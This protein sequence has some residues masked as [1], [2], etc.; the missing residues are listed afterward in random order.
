MTI[1]PK[2]TQEQREC[3]TFP[4][5]SPTASPRQ[6]LIIEA[7]AGAGKTAVLAERVMWKLT[8]APQEHRV[9]PYE[10]FLAT[11]TR[12][13]D[14]ELRQRVRQLLVNSGDSQALQMSALINISTIDSL[15]M[16]LFE[17]HY[18]VFWE[19]AFLNPDSPANSP[20]MDTVPQPQ[21]VED[22][23]ACAE[24]EKGLVALLESSTPNPMDEALLLDFLLAGALKSLKA[25]GRR[26][27]RDEIL[28]F[29]NSEACLLAAEPTPE[30]LQDS[31]HPALRSIF[32]LLCEYG[33][34][35]HLK[36]LRSGQ[37]THTDRL[38][39]LHN[40]FCA[41]SGDMTAVRSPR[42]PSSLIEPQLPF[43]FRELIVD[44]YQDTNPAQHELLAR[45]AHLSQAR[46]IVVGDPKQSLYG[47]RR[48]KVSVFHDLKT[49]PNW[50]HVELLKNFRSAPE[51]LRELNT[52]S[53]EALSFRD[54]SIPEAFWASRHGQAALRNRVLGRDLLA[55]KQSESFATAP[56]TPR[57]QIY[58]QSLNKK[59]YPGEALD[60]G[61]ATSADLSLELLVQAVQNLLASGRS[62][63]ECVVLCETNKDCDLVRSA[64][65]RAGVP[66]VSSARA[67][68]QN[69]QLPFGQR[70]A[71]K[72]LLLVLCDSLEEF[73]RYSSL[74]AFEIFT[75]P[76]LD[77]SMPE[78]AM[79]VARVV[80]TQPL[81]TA[82]A[83][84]PDPEANWQQKLKEFAVSHKRSR[85]LAQSNLFAAWRLLARP[86]TDTPPPP[87]QVEDHG[88]AGQ[89][90][91]E[92]IF[93]SQMKIWGGRFSQAFENHIWREELQDLCKHTSN[94]TQVAI[95][96]LSLLPISLLEWQPQNDGFSALSAPE[97]LRVM[98][99]HGAKGLQWPV[100]FFMPK[101]SGGSDLSVFRSIDFSDRNVVQWL[102]K[103]DEH[104]EV[105]ERIQS[106][107]AVKPGLR[108]PHIDLSRAKKKTDQKTETS[109]QQAT[110][111]LKLQEKAEKL[112]E[113]SR[114]FYTA[115][116]RAEE[117]LV[118][119]AGRGRK[120]NTKSLR[121]H[122]SSLTL[123][124][125]PERRSKE[126]KG[127]IA[128]TLGS[129]VDN[130]FLLRSEIHAE[131]GRKRSKKTVEPWLNSE[132][133]Q[134]KPEHADRS[135]SYCDRSA[136]SFSDRLKAVEARLHD[137]SSSL[138]ETAWIEETAPHRDRALQP[139]SIKAP[140]WP[141][142]WEFHAAETQLTSGSG[143]AK[144]TLAA[145][146]GNSAHDDTPQKERRQ[147]G[148]I[149]LIQ[150]GL[151][152]HAERELEDP[153][154]VLPSPGANH[155]GA[156]SQLEQ[157]SVLLLREFE[158]WTQK[159]AETAPG[160]LSVVDTS[161]HI[162][163]LICVCKTSDLPGGLPPASLLNVEEVLQ[164][165]PSKKQALDEKA[166]PTLF[167]E[168]PTFT[169][170][171]IDYKT[172]RPAIGH[173]SQ[174]VRYLNAVAQVFTH[175]SRYQ[176]FLLSRISDFHSEK[177]GKHNSPLISLSAYLC[178]VNKRP[179][180]QQLHLRALTPEDLERCRKDEEAN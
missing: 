25:F 93:F 32:N 42:S 80:A 19:S 121:D 96:L 14:K 6:N 142:F 4:C 86:L 160:E 9:A 11:F 145:Q 162:V 69:N 132:W 54:P 38:V 140:P 102:D 92:E 40:L 31:E 110:N 100:V 57:L 116:T 63:K 52:L 47:F 20:Q 176:R 147:E 13:A 49:D 175:D 167:E 99:V 43:A 109:S 17:S 39:F 117:Q 119:F 133:A 95:D 148:R 61:Q 134:L 166:Q 124:D 94:T 123:E 173:I 104:L 149:E 178:Y 48:A 55:G 115:I 179:V 64:L 71:L 30:V 174:M 127:L 130:L 164:R 155:S 28:S 37:I 67:T 112:F 143:I 118:L 2:F 139:T 21:L 152:F 146:I 74:A 138:E 156:L 106:H 108:I 131:K 23:L 172:G 10:L 35:W 135:V 70:V 3:V 111:E 50:H 26:G 46:M 137:S 125:P 120:G 76:L 158:I 60:L 171:V 5:E 126:L 168:P 85:E 36:R 141:A 53:K 1:N 73:T 77:L 7:G 113:R 44:E 180:P 177:N 161:R 82:R 165:N 91:R 87:S 88:Q 72:L 84:S 83:T 105:F 62:A 33:R 68:G 170:V 114:I 24:M 157:K 81:T 27:A 75:S 122:L 103:T 107:T 45:L 90:K 159:P 101:Q 97:S 22:D 8:A 144:E 154:S 58:T 41:S 15:L 79:A 98:T 16:S 169:V 18:A 151:L 89:D 150:E 51:L 29:L 59:R 65:S 163:D 66:C 129:Y 153:T 78:A 128:T 12:A 34:R 136:P 56:P